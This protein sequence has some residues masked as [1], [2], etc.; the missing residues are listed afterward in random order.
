M[1]ADPRL[2]RVTDPRR[3]S[4]PTQPPPPPPPALLEQKQVGGLDGADDIHQNGYLQQDE[5][6]LKLRFC[7]VCASNQNRYGIIY[8]I[9]DCLA[10]REDNLP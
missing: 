8:S 6:K 2:A 5:N 10:L 7:T 9:E 1:S 4:T 3:I